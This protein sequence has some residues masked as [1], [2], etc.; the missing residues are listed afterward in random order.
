VIQLQFLAQVDESKCTGCE[1]C[2]SVCP[3]GAI[4]IVERKATINGDRCIDCQRCIDRCNKENAIS[5]APRPSAIIRYVDY[6]D[7]DQL[8]LKTLCGKAGLL[9]DMPVCGCT[10]TTGKE[11]VAAI[12]KGAKTP[13]D[14]CAMTGLRAGCGIYCIT[15]IFQLLQA[16]GIELDNPPDRRWIKL[17]LSLSDIPEEKVAQ[18]DKAYPQCC[19][20]EDWK[21]VKR[22]NTHSPRKEDTR[23]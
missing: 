5:R 23:V 18:I 22:R 20:G 21:K 8:Q 2:E 19:V 6:S 12:L 4:E 3:A 7:V 11:A 16:C 13:E 1:L 10:R 15:R 9:P 14:L 17:T